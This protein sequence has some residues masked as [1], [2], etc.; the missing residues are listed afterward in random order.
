MARGGRRRGSGSRSRSVRHWHAVDYA[1]GRRRENVRPVRVSYRCA[2]CGGQFDHVHALADV[3]TLAVQLPPMCDGCYRMVVHEALVESPEVHAGF[4]LE[5][6][7]RVTLHGQELPEG[8][9][10]LG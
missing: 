9:E 2:V 8:C 4:T 6:W 5:E 3:E 1:A 10:L 7:I